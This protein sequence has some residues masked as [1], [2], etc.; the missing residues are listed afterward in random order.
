MTG[1]DGLWEIIAS[2]PPC[3]AARRTFGS[4]GRRTGFFQP[5][6]SHGFCS[7]G[8][9]PRL[10]DERTRGSLATE[11]AG[12]QLPNWTLCKLLMT[13]L[14]NHVKIFNF[15]LFFI[16]CW[17]IEGEKMPNWHPAP[18]T[19]LSWRSLASQDRCQ[20]ECDFSQKWY[21]SPRHNS[22][23]SPAVRKCVPTLLHQLL[24]PRAS[25]HPARQ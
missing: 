21:P 16:Y 18:G 12:Q 13:N 20:K 17:I 25:K 5:F 24:L 10:G 4:S 9:A 3:L 23:F 2:C 14:V 22:G 6:L 7:W 1:V 11:R 19:S 15:I 8:W